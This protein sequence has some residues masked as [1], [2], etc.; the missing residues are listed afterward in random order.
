MRKKIKKILIFFFFIF[1]FLIITLSYLRY[2]ALKRISD[3]IKLYGAYSTLDINPFPPHLSVTGLS[4]EIP[5]KIG[6]LS[7]KNAKI[8]VSTGG[9]FSKRLKFRVHLDSPRFVLYKLKS[10]GGKKRKLPNFDIENGRVINGSFIFKDGEREITFNLINGSMY[11]KNERL[12]LNIK[13]SIGRITDKKRGL[14][15]EFSMKLFLKSEM[16]RIKVRELKIESEYGVIFNKGTIYMGDDGFEAEG[17]LNANLSSLLNFRWKEIKGRIE[18]DYSLEKRKEN[19]KGRLELSIFPQINGRVMN[20]FAS[21]NFDEK[22]NGGALLKS[23]YK[24]NNWFCEIQFSEGKLFNFNLQN[25]HLEFLEPFFPK[26]PSDLSLNFNGE[27]RKNE[28]NGHF[29]LFCGEEESINGDVNLKEGNYVL[30]VNEVKIRGI[31]GN[32]TLN[33]RGKNIEGSGKLNDISLEDF[34][35]SKF[36]KS[37]Y[38]S[39][40]PPTIYGKG[41]CEFQISGTLRN[42]ETKGEINF[43]NLKVSGINFGT[44]KGEIKGI[45]NNMDF[46]GTLKDGVFEGNVKSAL[47]EKKIELEIIK[48]KAGNIW[49]ELKGEFKGNA[50][51][52][53]KDGLEVE[54]KIVSNLVEFRDLEIRDFLIPISFK[55][56]VLNSTFSFSTGLSDVNG[57]LEFNIDEMRYKVSVSQMVIDISKLYNELKGRFNFSFKGEGEL[58]VSPIE[59]RGEI[60]DIAYKSREPKNFGFESLLLLSKDKIFVNSSAKS[61]SKEESINFELEISR[62]GSLKGSFNGNIVNIEKLIEFP[63]EGVKVRF[64]GEL[65]G[66][67]KSLEIKS[68][69]HVEGNSFFIKGFAHDFRDFSGILVQENRSLHMRNFKAKIGGGDLEGYG[70]ANIGKGT[71]ENIK[72]NLTGKRMRLS[73]FERVNGIGDGKIEIRGNL[74][75]IS[76]EGGFFIQSLLWRKEIGERIAFSSTPSKTSSKIFKKINLNI[77]L[78][79]DGNAWMENSWGKA[80]G[81]FSLRIK[82]DSSNP[83][84]LGNITG[85]SGELNIGDRKFRLVRAEVYFNSPFIIDPEIYILADTFVKDYRVTFEVK[86]KSSKPIPQLSSSPPLSPQ[87]I[88]TLLALGEIYQRTSY[89]TGTQL[90]S[91]SLLS[92][93]ISEQLKGRAKKMLGVDR[94]RVDPYLLGSS[95]NPVARL[96]VGKKVSKDLIILY[97]SD[98][99]G[100]REYIVYI[101]YSISDNLSLIGMRNENGALSIDLKFVKRLGQ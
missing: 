83:V 67:P 89:R 11:Y 88:L 33:L 38:T 92:M 86:G 99:S 77:E 50:I 60:H 79:A 93:E 71:L 10:G 3:F 4:I 61:K 47:K 32:G 21:A 43:K 70:E 54:G 96:T 35:N 55:N 22:L 46:E 91:A 100:Q 48:G 82:G 74:N 13:N 98:L 14:E 45:K 51:I 72:I 62:D 5:D 49:N 16:R 28:L 85:K 1:L 41:N 24:N 53:F 65:K 20:L 19:L 23:K 59:I 6:K 58:H 8:E 29:L 36:L 56:G 26:I 95:S 90:G 73:P 39:S 15:K 31:Q 101:E 17:K 2:E 64:I 12:G 40:P 42:P 30:N 76:V 37:F 81:K 66:K 9:L 75:E 7:L 78:R 44:L 94:L 52:N 87:D 69:S 80:E 34:F 27:F 63:G 57:N 25:L 68:I 84:I 97:S 18:G